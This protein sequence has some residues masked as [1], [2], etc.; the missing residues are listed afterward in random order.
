VTGESYGECV[1]I[2]AGSHG[3]FGARVLDGLVNDFEHADVAE[4]GVG[5]DVGGHPL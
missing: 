4:V 1:R 5:V 2:V 3:A